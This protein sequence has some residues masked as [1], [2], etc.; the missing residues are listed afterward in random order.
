[1]C[2]Q[3]QQLDLFQGKANEDFFD[4][5]LYFNKLSIY[6]KPYLAIKFQGFGA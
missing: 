5:T 4:C 6:F 3:Q 1:M 2:V